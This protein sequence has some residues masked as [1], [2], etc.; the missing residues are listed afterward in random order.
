M[1][2][3]IYSFSNYYQR[4]LISIL[5]IVQLIISILEFSTLSLIPVLI[6]YLDNPTRAV[7]KIDNFQAYLS[8]NYFNI[9]FDVSLYLIFIFLIVLVIFKNI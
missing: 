3:S 1:L 4:L 9:N 2:K 6:L 8:D 5:F 7:E